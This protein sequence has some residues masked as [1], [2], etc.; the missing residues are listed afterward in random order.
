M[1]LPFPSIDPHHFRSTV[2]DLFVH[3]PRGWHFSASIRLKLPLV[4]TRR[5]AA[6]RRSNGLADGPA[7]PREACSLYDVQHAPK[8]DR[9]AWHELYR[10]YR[11][12]HSVADFDTTFSVEPRW[13]D[14]WLSFVNI[15][16]H[17]FRTFKTSPS[18]HNC[19][20]QRSTPITIKRNSIVKYTVQ[21]GVDCGVAHP[22]G[23]TFHNKCVA[24]SLPKSSPPRSR[25]A[26]VSL[27]S[28]YSYYRVI[29]SPPPLL[30]PPL[31]R[32]AAA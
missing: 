3:V 6:G 18:Y 21:A 26:H 12:H 20:W 15:L 22:P 24:T 1:S 11:S 14:F 9:S 7:S 10:R 4:Q 16:F 32:Q 25:G 13:K 27:R 31:Q 19:L 5:R 23:V 30:P 2:P 29:I 17:P 28:R 8:R